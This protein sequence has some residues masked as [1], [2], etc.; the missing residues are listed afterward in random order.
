VFRK[1]AIVNVINRCNHACVY[2]SEGDVHDGSVVPLETIE[3]LLD[4]LV[5]RGYDAV[6]FMGAETTLRRDVIELLRRVRDRGLKASL[7][8][9]GVRLSD[10]GF[11]EQ[12]VPLLANI[13]VSLPGADPDTYR[14]ITGRD[15]VGRVLTG[16]AHVGAVARAMAEPP[17][18]VVNTVVCR[19]NADAPAAVARRLASVDLG[20]RPLLH[21]IRAR[22][23]GRAEG[24]DLALDLTCVIESFGRGV[25][26]ADQAGLPVMFRGLPICCLFERVENNFWAL[27]ALAQPDNTYLNK[28]PLCDDAAIDDAARL[29]RQGRRYLETCGPCGLRP[30]CPGLHHETED[31]P[32]IRPPLPC[33]PLGEVRARIAEGPIAEQV[34]G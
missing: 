14:T 13:E 5:E 28:K 17:A 30:L 12:L 20:P 3:G 31:H 7:T 19:L 9:N 24:G 8:T 21:F 4:G 25:A 10:H 27:E 15:H 18:V 34:L 22:S 23:K 16:L 29:D 2:C 33:P 1:L 11:T 6:N 26:A 32:C